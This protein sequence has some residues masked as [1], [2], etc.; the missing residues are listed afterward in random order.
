MGHGIPCGPTNAGK[1]RLSRASLDQR[2]R[3]SAASVRLAVFPYI[4]HPDD[5]LRLLV[6][7]MKRMIL[8]SLAVLGDGAIKTPDAASGFLN[9]IASRNENIISNLDMLN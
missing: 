7:F 2:E 1:S 8:A 6:L 5:N 4:Q 3:R 9:I